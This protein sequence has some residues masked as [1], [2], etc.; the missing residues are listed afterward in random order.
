VTNVEEDLKNIRN[1]LRY[2][3]T[4]R[5]IL[6]SLGFSK[7]ID[8]FD[9]YL[10]EIADRAEKRSLTTDKQS[11]IE[12][13]VKQSLKIIKDIGENTSGTALIYKLITEGEG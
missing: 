12:G 9:D 8:E 4:M 7:N 1:E 10:L 2:C 5:D 6:K 11:L 3:L 13:S